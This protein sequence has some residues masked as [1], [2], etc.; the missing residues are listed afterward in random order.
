MLKEGWKYIFAVAALI[1]A[2]AFAQQSFKP[3]Y[4]TNGPNVN[5]GNNPVFSFGG[6]LN[7]TTDTILTAP[8]NQLAIITDVWLTMSDKSCSSTIQ[9]ANSSGDTLAKAKLHS[10]HEYKYYSSSGPKALTNSQPS[11][12]QHSF[13]SGLSV[14]VGDNLEITESGGCSIAYTISGYYAT[15]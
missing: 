8:S 6:S 2:V 4:A 7:S 1:A 14:A 12:I 10:Y 3:A 9:I 5:Y 15:P 11:S 13:K